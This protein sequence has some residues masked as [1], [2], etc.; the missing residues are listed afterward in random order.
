MKP[1]EYTPLTAL[2]FAEICKEAGLPDGVFNIVNGA[3]ETGALLA[4][5]PGV[6]KLSL[7]HI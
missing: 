3:G 7:I 1:A 2:A 6:Q 4:A 5:H